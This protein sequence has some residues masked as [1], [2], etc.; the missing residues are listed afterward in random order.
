MRIG[1]DP[2][3]KGGIAVWDD[4]EMKLFDMPTMPGIAKKGRKIDVNSHE[5]L[6]LILKF[7]WG[8][9]RK[10]DLCINIERV[11]STPQMGVVS[12]FKFGQTFGQIYGAALSVGVEVRMIEPQ[13]WKRLFGLQRKPKDASRLLAIKNYPYLAGDLKRKKDVGKADALWI[14]LA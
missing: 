9:D 6:H 11:H 4:K 14:A 1:I 12:A 3:I 8:V 5:L 7:Q 10:E 13:R 2:D